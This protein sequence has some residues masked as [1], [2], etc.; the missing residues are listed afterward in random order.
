MKPTLKTLS[1]ICSQR[2]STMNKSKA[3]EA[4]KSLS[5]RLDCV[6]PKATAQQAKIAMIGGRPRKYDPANV[7]AAKSDLLNLLLPHA[8]SRPFEGPLK[9]SVC[10]EYP[11]RKSESKKARLAGSKPCD[12]RP[13]ID[14]LCK[15]F[16]DAMT[17]ARFWNDDSQVSSLVWRKMWSDDSGITVQILPDLE[18]A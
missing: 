9:V 15:S 7:K 16:F 2:L 18:D 5:F 3:K 4:S 14:N 8:P 13:D 10:W 11:W 17:R 1:A 12:T 6:P